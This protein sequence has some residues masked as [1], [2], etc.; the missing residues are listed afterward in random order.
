MHFSPRRTQRSAIRNIAT[1]LTAVV[2]GTATVGEALAAGHGRGRGTGHMRGTIG[3]PIYTP[4]PSMPPI[5]NP[6][7]RYTVPQTP[8]VPVSPASPGSIFGNN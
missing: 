2:I 4:V 1:V 3:G 7:Y 8:E 6:S 5:F